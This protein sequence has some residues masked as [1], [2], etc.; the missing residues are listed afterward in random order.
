LFPNKL[1]FYALNAFCFGYMHIIFHNWVAVVLTI[2]GGFL[3]AVT[4][5]KTRSTLLVSIE[6]SLFGCLIFT[7]GLGEFFYKGTV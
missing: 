5:N 1:V 2:I 6:H 7:I 3:F 4:Y